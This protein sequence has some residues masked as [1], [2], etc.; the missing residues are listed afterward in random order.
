MKL[1]QIIVGLAV[2]SVI[3]SEA[4]AQNRTDAVL[5]K[6][7][8]ISQR[9][10][11]L[12]S[13]LLELAEKTGLNI[14]ADSFLSDTPEKD[15]VFPKVTIQALIDTIQTKFSREAKYQSGILLFR[16]RNWE[17]RTPESYA[18]EKV[19]KGKDEGILFQKAPE[20]PDS[21]GPVSVLGA[22]R[23]VTVLARRVRIE[24]LVESLSAQV[25]WKIQV[26]PSVAGRRLT[27]ALKDVPINDALAAITNVLEA[28]Q[29]VT[30]GKSAKQLAD[31]KEARSDLSQE[32]IEASN[33][34]LSL[35]LEEMSPEQQKDVREGKQV[36]MSLKDLPDSLKSLC[37]EYIDISLHMMKRGGNK[38]PVDLSR[39]GEAA[40]T[41]LPPPSLR[42]VSVSVFGT[43][44]NLHSF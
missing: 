26:D 36:T 23:K 25:G 20:K 18:S 8:S 32:A 13:V 5:Q 12:S 14:V 41:V 6:Q 39:A 2:L 21:D 1:S 42:R 31:E 3:G 15:L 35:L 16:E 34:L 44:G 4:S 10:P 7:I 40:I 17:K 11:V 38:I 43:D 24:E 9:N 22:T 28:S 29:V 37:N 30:I 27:V 33:K 19:Y